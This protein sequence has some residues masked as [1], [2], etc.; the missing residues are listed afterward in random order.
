MTDPTLNVILTALPPTLVAAA[1]V[2]VS[3]INSIKANRI[4]TL[5]N[6]NLDAVKTDLALAKARIAV[7]EALV[8]ALKGQGS[9]P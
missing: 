8:V 1:G 2:V 5:V 6:S 4:H 7:L 3:V 9:L